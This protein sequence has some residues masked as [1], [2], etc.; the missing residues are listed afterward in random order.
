MGMRLGLGM[1]MR[2]GMGMGMGMELGLVSACGDAACA[3]PSV[4]GEC[5]WEGGGGCPGKRMKSSSVPELLTVTVWSVMY[6]PTRD[7]CVGTRYPQSTSM[8]RRILSP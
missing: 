8:Y 4:V 5:G 3:G 2:M 7:N 6:V 1:G